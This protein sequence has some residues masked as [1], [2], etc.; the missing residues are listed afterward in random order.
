MSGL[1]ERVQ[2]L[3]STASMLRERAADA[4]IRVSR[5]TYARSRGR[6][7]FLNLMS[8]S[9]QQLFGRPLDNPLAELSNLLYPGTLLTA[10]SVR[11][12][13]RKVKRNR[14]SADQ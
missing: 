5:Q 13:R 1:C 8:S 11:K 3:E 7:L 12:A 9:S 10:E 6:K 2:W 4:R 14:P